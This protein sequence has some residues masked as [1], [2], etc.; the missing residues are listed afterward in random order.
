[1]LKPIEQIFVFT[2]RHAAI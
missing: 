1:L 2:W